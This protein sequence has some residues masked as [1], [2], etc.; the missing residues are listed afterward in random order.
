MF[1]YFVCGVRV[2]LRCQRCCGSDIVIVVDHYVCGF[3]I[4]ITRYGHYVCGLDIKLVIISTDEK[5]RFHNNE[6]SHNTR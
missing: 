4:G 1:C 6:Q 5:K 3:D 2:V